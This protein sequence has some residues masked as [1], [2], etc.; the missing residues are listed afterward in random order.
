[1]DESGC[2]GGGGRANWRFLTNHSAVLLRIAQRPR[3]QARRRRANDVGISQRAAQMILRDLVAGGFVTRRRVGR[4]NTYQIHAPGTFAPAGG[5]A[6][7]TCSTFCPPTTPG[8]H[9]LAIARRADQAVAIVAVAGPVTPVA[10]VFVI[11]RPDVSAASM[12]ESSR[13]WS[14]MMSI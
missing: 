10:G 6:Y 4:R 3:Y 9:G 1:M 13:L 11:S 8:A 7:P 2:P 12:I 5:C 14:L